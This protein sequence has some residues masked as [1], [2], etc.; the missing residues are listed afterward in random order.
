M[1]RTILPPLQTSNA[2]GSLSFTASAGGVSTGYAF[3]DFLM[4]VPSSTQEVPVRPQLLLRQS[5]V[6]SFIQDDWRISR[7]LTVYLGLR[8]E[9]SFAPTEDNNRITTFDPAVNGIVVA[10]SN[11][12]LP[13][14]QYV[15]S[16][17]AKLAP[18]GTFPFPVV[19]AESA[20][21][22]GRRLVNTEFR[23]F[24][25]RVGFAFDLSGKGRTV[26]RSGY[27]IFYTRYPIQYLQQTAFVNPPFAGVFNYSQ[28]VQ[29]G[30]PALTI[31]TPYP[32]T[33]GN[34]SVSPAGLDRNFKQPDN[35]QWNLTL[36]QYLGAKTSFSIGYTGN[37][38]THL[39]RTMDMN[40]PRWIP[41][42]ARWCDRS[43][44]HSAPARFRTA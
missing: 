18:N 8:H 19:A 28:S 21:L 35:Q 15:P 38:G 27:G 17:V 36:E 29:N 24:G 10:S 32:A 37:K 6:A 7:R 1:R 40:G 26:L 44:I 30:R 25:P 9:L 5:E 2:R 39:F 42:R 14:D 23:N 43:G 16:V 41:R 4:G 34:P 13:V 22:D 33:G 20:G 11:G 31:D 12:K 3:A